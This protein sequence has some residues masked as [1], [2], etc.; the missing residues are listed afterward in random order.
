MRYVAS[1]GSGIGELISVSHCLDDYF[2]HR[3]AL[4]D[5]STNAMQVWGHHVIVTM[6]SS[7]Y[8]CVQLGHFI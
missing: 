5:G 1:R 7:A 8:E 2:S 4:T 3:F 6:F